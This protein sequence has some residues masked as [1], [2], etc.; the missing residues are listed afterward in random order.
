MSDE[1]QS[2]VR[3]FMR[4]RARIKQLAAEEGISQV[5]AIDRCVQERWEKVFGSKRSRQREIDLG[6]GE[7]R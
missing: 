3:V 5:E 4:T 6:G 2:M 1:K 7:D